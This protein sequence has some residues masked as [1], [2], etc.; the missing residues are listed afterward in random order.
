MTTVTAA[1]RPPAAK[2]VRAALVVT[3]SAS[4]MAG[5]VHAAA[6]RAHD[7]DRLLVWMFVL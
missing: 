3:V 4:A 1:P 5:L 6:A 2:G 7:G